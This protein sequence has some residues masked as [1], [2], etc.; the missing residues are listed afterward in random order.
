MYVVKIL[1]IND[2]QKFILQKF[3]ICLF[4]FFLFLFF[5]SIELKYVQLLVTLLMKLCPFKVKR[6]SYVDGA[7]LGL[8]TRF[9]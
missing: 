1:W 3:F 8:P 4:V 6:S 2:L 5:I 9:A 7:L